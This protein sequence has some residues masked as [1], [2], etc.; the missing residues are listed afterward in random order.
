MNKNYFELFS[1]PVAFAIDEALL[2]QRYR[3][4]LLQLHP[5][6]RP[7]VSPHEKKEATLL[8]A[9]VHDAFRT[10]LS[11]VKRAEYLLQLLVS[12]PQNAERT[13]HD[14]DLLTQQLE[15]REELEAL[16]REDVHADEL[17]LFYEKIKAERQRTLDALKQ[18]FDSQS[19]DLANELCV[20][21][22]FIERLLQ[23]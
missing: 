14:V 18:A 11:P 19:Y 2:Q 1:L 15:W 22:K 12:M 21:L 17:S 9:F 10:L 16:K 20:K 8:L 3:E 7:T 5:D 6:R 23:Q 4:L 13:V